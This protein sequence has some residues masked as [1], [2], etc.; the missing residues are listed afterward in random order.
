MRTGVTPDRSGAN[1]PA[2]AYQGGN[3]T[4]W[5]TSDFNPALPLTP[6]QLLLF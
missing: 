4:F 2:T 6:L 5:E 1:L 3:W